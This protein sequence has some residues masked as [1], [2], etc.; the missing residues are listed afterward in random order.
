[1]K[2]AAC[3]AVATLGAVSAFAPSFMGAQV[4]TRTASKA[5]TSMSAQ[6]MLGVDVETRGLWDPLNFSKD[7]ASLFRRRAVE[8]KHG[9][10]CMLA[11]LGYFVAELWHPLYDGKIPAGLAAIGQVP[12][13]GW[14]QIIA[15]IGIIELTVGKQ[16]YE[17][18]GPGELGEFGQAFNPFKE[19]PEAFAA[20]QLKE[21][22]NGRLA[23]VAFMGLVIQEG[24]T[25]QTPLEQLASGH[26]SPFGDGQGFF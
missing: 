11:T 3:V 20:L 23:Q 19:D 6:D 21:L 8:L 13:A 5:T 9:R 14:L 10:I 22:K 17:N 18:K 25:G 24:L 2:A 26:I 16:D 4:A 12:A 15:A 7:E 1:M